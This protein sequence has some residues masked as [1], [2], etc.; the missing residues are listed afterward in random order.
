MGVR[1][2]P[3]SMGPQHVRCGMALLGHDAVVLVCPSMG[4]QHVRCGMLA[5]RKHEHGYEN[6]LQWGRNMF[7]AECRPLW[8]DLHMH[9]YTFNGAATC[10]LR[11]AVAK[12]QGFL[13]ICCPSMGPQHVRCGISIPIIN[14]T[15]VKPFNGAATCSLRNAAKRMSFRHYRNRAFNGAAT[16]SLRNAVRRYDLRRLRADPSMG[17]QHVRCGMRRLF[18]GVQ[19]AT[20]FLQWGRN[21][22]VAE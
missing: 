21:M 11:N 1:P 8:H 22:F 2:V 17:P 5:M 4:P 19:N 14:R 18:D 15:K 9:D 13:L 16:C 12:S 10:S 20:W 6:Y 7:V 3:P